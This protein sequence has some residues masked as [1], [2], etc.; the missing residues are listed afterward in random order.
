MAFPILYFW[1]NSYTHQ[2]YE[3]WHLP[4]S[5]PFQWQDG[6][7][8]PPG[9]FQAWSPATY[10][11]IYAQ[12]SVCICIMTTKNSLG[13]QDVSHFDSQL[14][15]CCQLSSFPQRTPP[16]D[17]TPHTW[18]WK[19][20]KIFCLLL[21]LVGVTV[22]FGASPWSPY[23]SNIHFPIYTKL[24]THVESVCLNQ[25]PLDTGSQ[26]N[27]IRFTWHLLLVFYTS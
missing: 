1:T 23:N 21:S 11:H 19:V 4:G 17:L 15:F 3:H 16:T 6:S 27:V 7:T 8:A 12:H 18:R 5:G 26:T 13:Q 22:N 20:I 9:R 24:L 10:M 2:S 25:H 14:R